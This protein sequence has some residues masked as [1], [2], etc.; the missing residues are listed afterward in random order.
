MVSDV[1][2]GARDVIGFL[3]S[4]VENEILS[5]LQDGAHYCHNLV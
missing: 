3:N 4:Y 1:E 5:E 2:G